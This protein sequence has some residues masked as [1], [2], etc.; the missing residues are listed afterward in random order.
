MLYFVIVIVHIFI[1][2]DGQVRTHHLKCV[3]HASFSN[4]VNN[5]N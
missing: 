3:D 5:E 4:I 1:H 2:G